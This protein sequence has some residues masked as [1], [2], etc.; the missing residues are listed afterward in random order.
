MYMKINQ[1]AQYFTVLY[2][3]SFCNGIIHDFICRLKAYQMQY[4]TFVNLIQHV[5]FFSWIEQ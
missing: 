4:I 3:G 2:Y 1:M 5:A